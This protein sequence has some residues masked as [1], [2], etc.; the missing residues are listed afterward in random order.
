MTEEDV[1]ESFTVQDVMDG[2]ISPVMANMPLRKAVTLFS[3]S[4][5]SAYPVV[6]QNEKIEGLLT[7]E[8]LKESLINQDCW[9]WL[10]VDDIT[11][12]LPRNFKT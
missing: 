7:F 9:D 1:I 3:Q 6:M 12:T 11:Q 10:V 8:A 4:E 2:T 5:A